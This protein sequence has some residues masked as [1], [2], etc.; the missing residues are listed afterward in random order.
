MAADMT[1]S[2]TKVLLVE[3]QDA[4]ADLVQ[5]I[6]AEFSGSS[7]HVSRVRSASEAA[8]R[9]RAE[10]IDVVLLDLALPD[11]HGLNTFCKVHAAASSVPVIVLTGLDDERLALQAMR[12]GAQDYLVKGQLEPRILARVLRYAIERKRGAEALRQSEEF[13]RLISE[14]VTDLI[15]VLD[16]N[17]HRL[18]NSPSYRR[19]LGDPALLVGTDS[20]E[21]IHPE[22]RPRVHQLFQDTVA[23]GAGHRAEYRLQ[24]RDG[25]ER[26]IESQGSVIRDESGEVAKVVVVARDITQRKEAEATVRH[27]LSEL[28]KSHHE[29]KATQLQLVQSEKLEAVS[30]FAAGVAHEVKNPLQ[31]IILGVDYLSNSLGPEETTCKMVLCEMDHAVHRADSIIRGLLEFSAY[32]KRDVKQQ[33]LS[34]IIEQSLESVGHELAAV[35]IKVQRRLATDLPFLRLDFKTMKHVFI[36]VFMNAIRAMPCGGTL[37]VKTEVRHVAER[38]SAF[39]LKPGDSVVVAEFDYAPAESSAERAAVS[40]PD[41]ERAV[42][43]SGLGLTVLKKILELY[44]G[45][46]E[47]LEHPNGGGRF[48][49]IFRADKS[50]A[51]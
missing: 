18:Y 31:A 2:A 46:I 41:P 23:T 3:D 24:L 36:N 32:N 25:T 30:T 13:F 49:I 26:Q 1:D 34:A 29:L 9:L 15:A 20:F 7:F 27:A 35:S 5:D 40:S 11:A 28:E 51:I 43:P 22:D 37:S 17:G 19:I 16:R 14:N 8:Q 21:E 45:M 39:R 48:T 12:E 6:L 4:F 47:I 42:K 38:Q 50:S 33:N 10:A 44:S